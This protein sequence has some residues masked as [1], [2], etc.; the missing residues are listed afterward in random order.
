MLLLYTLQRFVFWLSA[1]KTENI[2]ALSIPHK[3]IFAVFST[4]RPNMIVQ[5]IYLML[6]TLNKQSNVSVK[7]V[8]P[9]NLII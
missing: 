6:E 1:T 2:T 9:K 5:H 3:F 7:F 4:L 8:N